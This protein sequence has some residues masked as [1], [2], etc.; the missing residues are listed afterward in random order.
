M[1]LPSVH[2]ALIYLMIVTSAADRD[3]AHIELGSIGEVVRT[4]PVF[5]DFDKSKVL[6]VAQ[7][8]QILLSADNGLEQV[9]EIAHTVIPSR[10]RDTAY[11]AVFE[12]A[13]ADLEMRLEEARILQRIREHLDIDALSVAAIEMATKA[14]VRTLT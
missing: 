13:A 12:V 2:E 3:M 10:L 14:R 4:W 9:L 11:A 1:A 5:E 8:C 7:D 6:D